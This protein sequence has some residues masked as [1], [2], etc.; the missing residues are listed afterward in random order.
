VHADCG[1]RLQQ[2]PRVHRVPGMRG[3]LSDVGTS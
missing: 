3:R 1:R 2:R